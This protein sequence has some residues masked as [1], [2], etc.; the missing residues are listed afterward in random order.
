MH[1]LAPSV[2]PGFPPKFVVAP[3]VFEQMQLYMDYTNPEERRIREF[4]MKMT[5]RDLS[6]NPGAQSSY[7]RHEDHPRISGVQ[8][9]NLG[10]V[11]DFRMAETDE[12]KSRPQTLVHFVPW[13]L[14]LVWK[15]KNSIV[16]AETQESMERLLRD[17]VNEVDQ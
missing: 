14:W 9:K 17:M 6:S 10:R 11:F 2:P 13:M 4:K 12:D 1:L 15:N 8:N 3:E 7:L 16:Y 5:L